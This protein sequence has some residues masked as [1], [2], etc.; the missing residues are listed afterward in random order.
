MPSTPITTLASRK[1][2]E[3]ARLQRAADQAI[4]ELSGFAREKGGTFVVFGSY[5]TKTMRFDSDLDIMLDFPDEAAADAWRFAEG[6]CARLG[7]PL[8]I[9]D[10]GS[11]KPEFAARVRKTGLVL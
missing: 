3:A 4:S 6:V 5:V 11:T 9:H 2:T 10:A 1:A 8:D 7:V